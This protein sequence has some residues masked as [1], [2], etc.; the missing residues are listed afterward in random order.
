MFPDEPI[1]SRLIGMPY[2]PWHQAT[3]STH[4]PP[5]KGHPMSTQS[6][7]LPPTTIN[8]N[9]ALWEQGDFT[10]I[11][12]SMRGSGEALVA[13]LDLQRHDTVLDLGCGDG[14]TALPAAR[15]VARVIGVDIAR[16]LVAAGNRRATDQGLSN[17]TFHTG[18]ATTLADLPDASVDVTL[19]VFGAMFAPR[20]FDVASAMVRVTRPGGRIVMGNWIPGDPTLVSQILKICSAYTPPPTPGFISPMTWGIESHV[21]DRFVHAGV[22]PER[23]AFQRETFTFLHAGDPSDFVR[24]FRR[25]Y[26]PTMNAFA[27]AEN[28]G[29]GAQ[30]QEELE[31]LF[32]RQNRSS[33]PGVTII[34][35]TFLLVTVAR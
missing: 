35:A 2:H 5:T 25:W 23:V 16:N 29:R 20:P 22:G 8:T 14:T 12:A 13:K 28:Q 10:R 31:E 34:P 18:C 19:S 21:I 3:A 7:L 32:T 9:Q 24:T 26:G 33:T 17:C 1:L 15:R 6:I 30:L 4:D 11:A 27:A